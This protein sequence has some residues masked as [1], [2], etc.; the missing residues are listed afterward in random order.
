MILNLVKYYLH[1]QIGNKGTGTVT[2][3]DVSVDKKSFLAYDARM[4]NNHISS[5]M[6]SDSA[7]S[8]LIDN[9]NAMITTYGADHLLVDIFRRDNAKMLVGCMLQSHHLLSGVFQYDKHNLTVLS[10]INEWIKFK[11]SDANNAPNYACL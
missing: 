2:W 6:F 9:L 4:T 3:S 7:K 11:G 10:M 8:G 1:I 5:S